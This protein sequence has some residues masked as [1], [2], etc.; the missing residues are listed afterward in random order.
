M[1]SFT[2]HD[3][4]PFLNQQGQ[5]QHSV[6]TTSDVTIADINFKGII[7]T[8][9]P[10]VYKQQKN[11]YAQVRGK[12]YSFSDFIIQTGIVYTGGDKPKSII[13]SV[14]YKP[15]LLGEMTNNLL[16]EFVESLD[17]G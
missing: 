10:T 6:K 2:V 12:R 1:S 9:V 7:Q 8:L 11:L 14:E 13:L 17:Q 3:P 16:R 4:A 15:C 5:L